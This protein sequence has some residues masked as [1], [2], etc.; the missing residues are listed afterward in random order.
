MTNKY[1][2]IKQ[3]NTSIL[4]ELDY[5]IF[6]ENESYTHK[7]E[8]VSYLDKI[9]QDNTIDVLIISNNHANYSLEKYTEKWNTFY[10]S[11]HWE[12]NILRVFRTYDE[13]FMKIKS[14]K[15]SIIFMNSKAVNLLLFN[16]SLAADLRCISRDFS[17]INNKQN[18]VNVPKGGYAHLNSVS[19]FRNPFKLLFLLEEIKAD[20]LYKRQLVDRV[21]TNELEIEVLKI[22]DH[23]ATFDYIELETVKIYDHNRLPK[24]E[25]ELQK[26]NEFLLSCIRTKINQK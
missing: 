14:L 15:K 11:L 26:E 20:T 3:H 9:G 18:M 1:F 16:F 4:L 5:M 12:N 23:L 13:L 17:I 6:L 19:A 21:Y 8:L 10:N 25:I 22:A 24:I 2:N 7:E